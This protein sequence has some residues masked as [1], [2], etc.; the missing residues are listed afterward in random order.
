VKPFPFVLASLGFALCVP[1]SGAAMAESDPTPTATPNPDV[2]VPA[3]SRQGEEFP[4]YSTFR[5][6]LMN[7]LGQARRR[8]A[9]VTPLLSDGD[10]ATALFAARMRGLGTLALLDARESKSYSSRHDYLARTQ[11]PTWLVP[12]AGFRMDAVTLVVIDDTAWRVGARFDDSARGSVRIEPAGV[13]PDEIFSWQNVRGARFAQDKLPAAGRG[14]GAKNATRRRPPSEPGSVSMDEAKSQKQ[15]GNRLPRRLPRETRLQRLTK[16][17][18]EQDG[19]EQ[20]TGSLKVPAPPP[21]ESD[22]VA[23]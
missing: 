7:V 1:L 11:V 4:S 6:E 21:N 20:S 3:W 15:S 19:G 18:Q 10:L 17:A 12:L 9:I 14:A 8:V 22:A 16:G 23:E 2:Y 5:D 13:T